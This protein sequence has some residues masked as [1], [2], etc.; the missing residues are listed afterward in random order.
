M[1]A[2]KKNGLELI[3]SLALSNKKYPNTVKYFPSKTELSREEAPSLRRS[4]PE[5]VGIPSTLI[6]SLLTAL[7]AEE[8]ANIQSMLIVKDGCVICEAAKAGYSARL[9]HLAHSMSKSV[10]GMIIGML[11]D[12]GHLKIS[13]RIEKF[14]PQ[15]DIHPETAKITIE[16]LLIMSS[17]IDFSEAGSVTDL[18][19]TETFLG[20]EPAFPQGEKFSYNSM[21]S[22][23]LMAIASEIISEDLGMSLSAFL[24]E[25]LFSPLGIKNY[26]WEKSPEGTEK[27]GWGLYLSLESFV[28]L[29]LMM[30]EGG[31]Y[32][33]RRILSEEWVVASTSTQSITPEGTG[34]F[35]YG[36]QIWVGRDSHDFLF[37]G[38]FGQNLL[39]IP[40]SNVIVAIN[41]GNNELFQ[42][43]PA[44]RI[45]REHLSD[46]EG[47]TPITARHPTL[48]RKNQIYPLTARAWILPKE[49]KRGIAE[50]FG[51]KTRTPFDISFNPLISKFTL[52]DN[53]Q[54]I[55]PLF[56]RVMQN[57]YQGG[58]ESLQF[59]RSNDKLILI[60][61]EGG[62]EYTYAVGIYGYEFSNIDY[63]G[64]KYIVGA[65]AAAERGADG[66]TRFKIEFI[67]P[68]LPN[69]RK[70]TLEVKSNGILIIDLTEIPDSKITESFIS[71]LPAMNPKINLM[72]DLLESNL[73]KN[74]IERRVAELF[75]PSLTAVSQ[76]AENGAELLAVENRKIEEKLS[77]MSIVRMMI[78]RF[79]GAESELDEGKKSPSIGGM[80]I[81]SLLG[82]LF[83]KGSDE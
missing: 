24:E 2:Y 72:L 7:E 3:S 56:V 45:I 35:N 83:S 71:S 60:S 10:T 80:I 1:K 30:A 13:D 19:W 39:V 53:A 65:M 12:G 74:F 82:K 75:S 62:K 63:C 27:G 50:F 58:I 70:M 54:G 79:T 32:N 51:L 66:K 26:F 77:S 14:F 29:G 69:T 5:S 36:Y 55:L 59:R 23:M 17:G 64:E 28:K 21:N 15:Y 4:S 48:L 78:S 18:R 38:M 34:D 52:A 81:S 47:L 25:R 73:G 8:R 40:K 31:V 49:K 43:S 22:Y 20:S 44:L 57:N 76:Y 61:T 42:E 9:A 16:N 46:T 11:V 68:E 67:Y 33:G 41:A 37:N 6:A